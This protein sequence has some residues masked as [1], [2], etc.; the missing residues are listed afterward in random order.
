MLNILDN[1]HEQ[2]HDDTV[3]PVEQFL[4]S[5]RMPHVWCPGCR[6]RHHRQR[7]RPCTDRVED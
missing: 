6:D 1:N 2:A 3:N 5:D 7:L 4:R